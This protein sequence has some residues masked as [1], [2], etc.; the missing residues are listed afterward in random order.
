VDSTTIHL[1]AQCVDWARHRRRKAAAKCHLRLDLHSFLP[2]FA[3]IDAA[4]VHDAARARALCAGVAP[5]EIVLF[6]KAYVDFEHLHQLHGRGVF[7]VSR[8]R[9]DFT[10]R[11]VKKLPRSKD[12]RVLRDELV[13]LKTFRS[14]RAWSAGTLADLYRSRWQIEVFFKQIKQTLQLSDFL[15][16]NERAVRWQL[17]S[18]LLCYVL[19]RFCG[20]LHRWNHSFTRLFTLVRSALW[21]RWELCS[22]LR[23]YGTA[24]GSFRFLGQPQQAWL[25][26]SG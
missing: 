10:C 11:V 6:D 26:F 24:D 1:V 8:A 12:P 2:R 19:L 16:N 14:A 25:A 18:A 3:I 23:L 5:G 21:Q 22:L 13:R 17:W 20:C 15:G 9:E 7:W 4:K